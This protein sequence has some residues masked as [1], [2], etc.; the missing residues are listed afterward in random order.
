[1][2][3][4]NKVIVAFF[5]A[6]SLTACAATTAKVDDHVGAIGTAQLLNTFIKFEQS[7]QQFNMSAQQN[8]QLELLP[9]DLVIDVYFGTWCHDSVREVPRLL[10]A[11][12]AKPEIQINLFGLDYHKLDPDGKAEQAGIKFTPTFIVSRQGKE[13][14]RIVERP[15][16]DLVTDIVSFIN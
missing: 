12:S 6:T 4:L 11:L 16:V 2:L 1:M 13:L 10:K 8:T 3:S 7:Y 15:Q 14:G 5:V 9:D